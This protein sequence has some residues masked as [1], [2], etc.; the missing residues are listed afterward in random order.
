MILVICPLKI[1]FKYLK[2]AFKKLNYKISTKPSHCFVQ[3][4]PLTLAV[5][6]HGK[7]NFALST[8]ELIKS[9]K[10][11]LVIC[12]G[13]AGGLK[14]TSHLDIIAATKTIEHDYKTLF[15]PNTPLPEFTGDTTLI[16]KISILD[17]VKTGVIASGDEDVV[18]EK[19]ADEIQKL[20]GAIAV[21]WEG[22]GGAKAC[23]KTNTP[24]LE[25]RFISDL[26]DEST[27]KDFKA[28]LSKGMNI[29]ASKL[30]IIS[31]ELNLRDL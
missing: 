7:V 1:E 12:A 16:K 4:T 26:C 21:A 3:D 28:N 23:K 14:G 6:G 31:K 19:R 15:E 20:T 2:E 17:K 5:G 9:L 30:L 24:F 18:S 27:H 11:D 29:I 13:A 8:F 22:A 25:L 10:P